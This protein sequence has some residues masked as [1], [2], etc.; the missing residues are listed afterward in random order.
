M[1]VEYRGQLCVGYNYDQMKQVVEEFGS[2]GDYEDLGFE[3]FAPYFDA[4]SS[5]CIYGH[6]ISQTDVYSYDSVSDK[7]LSEIVIIKNQ[8]YHKYLITP[9]LYIMAEGY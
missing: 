1:S 4:A 8:M 9:H 7:Q 3:C 2:D 5:D 6:S